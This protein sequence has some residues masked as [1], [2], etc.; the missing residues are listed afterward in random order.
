MLDKKRNNVIK[1]HQELSK[2]LR[3]LKS[4]LPSG[5]IKINIF[6]SRISPIRHKPIIINYKT[7]KQ[8]NSKN[9]KELKK[10]QSK[11]EYLLSEDNV[12]IKQIASKFKTH[13]TFKKHKSKLN[14]SN[15]DNNINDDKNKTQIIKKGYYDFNTPISRQTFIKAKFKNELISRKA[16][17]NRK[18]I[19]TNSGFKYLK[20]DYLLNQSR[21]NFKSSSIDNSIMKNNICLPSITERLQSKLP[22]YDREQNDLFI[23]NFRINDKTKFKK[24]QFNK[25]FNVNI[26]TNKY[27]SGNKKIHFNDNYLNKIKNKVLVKINSIKK[28]KKEKN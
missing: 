28:V 22:R 13:F 18:K 25:S 8:I 17:N 5:F 23:E 14:S 1:I 11:N 21:K 6:S 3:D 7:E 15:N 2:T 4:F 20:L 16:L 26:K 24:I 19:K 9:S 12:D 27:K 10:S